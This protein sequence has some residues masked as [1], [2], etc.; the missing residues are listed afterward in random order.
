MKQN[1]SEPFSQAQSSTPW[2]SIQLLK[3]AIIFACIVL[4]SKS[5]VDGAPKAGQESHN[6]QKGATLKIAFTFDDLPAHSALPL[7][8][9][10]A[11]IAQKIVTALHNE[12]MPPV[13]GMVT[14]AL[15]EKKHE[16]SVVLRIWHD[17]GNPLGNHT[18]SH[19]HLSQSA[20]DTFESEITRNEPT[21]S[22]VMTHGDWHWFRYPFL[23]E[24]EAPEKRSQIRKYLAAHRYKVAA[25]TMSFGDYMWNEPY[26]RCVAKNDQAAI[27]ELRKS[28]LAAAD[29]S[30]TRYREMSQKLYRRDIPYVL[31]M[32]IGALDA[33][34][35]PQLLS[36]YRSRA[37]TFVSLPE[38]ESDE[39]Y[40]ADIHPDQPLRPQSLEDDMKEK[41]LT[42]PQRNFELPKFE[43][44]CR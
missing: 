8:T 6:G 43:S 38:A 3:S 13:H 26:A 2:T 40:S 10:R 32:H 20:P 31:L 39:H 29:E 16:D 22:S 35:L 23:D 7:N 21:I 9:T 42:I 36:L 34:M 18:W 15:I 17:A 12:H 19:P 1:G 28:Y 33:E 11:E 5:S 14:G 30:I 27:A 37:F 41:G 44:L 24:G 4:A 25:V